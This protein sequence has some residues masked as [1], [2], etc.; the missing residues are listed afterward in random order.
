MSFRKRDKRLDNVRLNPKCTLCEVYTTPIK[1]T[2]GYD[3]MVRGWKCPKCGITF[4]HPD[5]IEYA[6]EII[7]EE[8]S[9]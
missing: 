8:D 7:R 5:D 3:I 1:I 4:I 9:E 2:K 6:I